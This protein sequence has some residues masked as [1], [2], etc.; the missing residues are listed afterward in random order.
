LIKISSYLSLSVE[1]A[2]ANEIATGRPSGI[3]TIKITMAI[4]PISVTCNIVL[5]LKTGEPVNK[6]Y[7]NM[8]AI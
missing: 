4:I 5:S 8:K 1:R 6:R 7:K 2:I 3:A